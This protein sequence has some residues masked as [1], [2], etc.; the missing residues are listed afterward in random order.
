MTILSDLYRNPKNRGNEKRKLKRPSPN[1]GR[2]SARPPQVVRSEPAGL[3]Y[4]KRS[5]Q[6]GKVDDPTLLG[7]PDSEAAKREIEALRFEVPIVA[8]WIDAVFLHFEVDPTILAEAVPF[9]LDLHEGKAYISLVAFTMRGMRP[10][11][12]GRATSWL[13]APIATHQF[14]NLRTYVKHRSQYGIFF[15]K[16]WLNDSLAVK[17]G[18]RT[19]GLP[20]H[21]AKIDY[22]HGSDEVHGTVTT[23]D[24]ALRYRAR[25]RG[26]TAPAEYGTLDAFLLERYTAFNN[27][28][29]R[30]KFFRVWHEPWKVQPLTNLQVV[31]DD[32]IRNKAHPWSDAA[33]L[34][35]GHFTRGVE[36][37]SMGRPHPAT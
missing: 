6:E 20:Y 23:R 34:I 8:D 5:I 26:A 32:L 7:R 15:M 19:F 35:G 31:R 11:R 9:E 25:P 29:R 2:D 36:G 13:T 22:D 3:A 30:P 4:R 14:L 28:G 18:P 37:V 10:K 17:L 21:Q 27:A 1:G 33:T 16:E 12:G 24:E